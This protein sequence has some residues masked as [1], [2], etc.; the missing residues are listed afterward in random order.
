MSQLTDLISRGV[1]KVGRSVWTD[2]DRDINM[3]ADLLLPLFCVCCSQ[4]PLQA[5]DLVG[6]DFTFSLI[7]ADGFLLQHKRSL[8]AGKAAVNSPLVCGKKQFSLVHC[9]MKEI[10]KIFIN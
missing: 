3:S 10:H 1:L 5:V 8:S 6:H 4:T 7:S 2:I 9:Q